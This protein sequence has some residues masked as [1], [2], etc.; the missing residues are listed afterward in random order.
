MVTALWSEE[1]GLGKCELM[2]LLTE[3]G[4]DSRPFFHPLSN[5]PAYE[6]SKQARW[7][8]ARNTV[9]YG[10][11][12]RGLNLPSGLNLTEEKVQYVCEVLKGILKKYSH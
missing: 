8:R 5:I 10:L 2:Q 4:I 7:A 6:K 12:P 9:S 3:K 11:A 1:F